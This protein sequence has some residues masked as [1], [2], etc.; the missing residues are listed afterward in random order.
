MDA[1]A[2]LFALCGI[3][4]FLA[5]VTYSPHDPSLNVVTGSD[6]I[7][8]VTGSGRA[9]WAEAGRVHAEPDAAGVP[10]A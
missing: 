3:Y 5:L 1:G 8:N 7:G 4:S 10:S 9:V 6:E 2:A